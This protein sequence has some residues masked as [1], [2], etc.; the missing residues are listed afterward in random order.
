MPTPLDQNVFAALLERYGFASSKVDRSLSAL[1]AHLFHAGNIGVNFEW[2]V[3]R[4][5]ELEVVTLK[6]GEYLFYRVALSEVSPEVVK[7]IIE[8]VQKGQYS[9]REAINS[10]PASLHMEGVP[11]VICQEQ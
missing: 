10:T 6:A 3:N 7:A 11:I 5:P 4:Q 9:F 8:A 1:H 2:H